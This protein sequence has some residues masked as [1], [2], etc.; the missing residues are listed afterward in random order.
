MGFF[1]PTPRASPPRCADLCARSGKAGA[2]SRGRNAPCAP[3]SALAQGWSCLKIHVFVKFSHLITS[4]QCLGARQQPSSPSNP[5]PVQPC[6]VR[7]PLCPSAGLLGPGAPSPC[8]HAASWPHTCRAGGARPGCVPPRTRGTTAPRCQKT[9]VPVDPQVPQLQPAALL[10]ENHRAK[11]PNPITFSKDL[12]LVGWRNALRHGAG[13]QG[14]G[15][16]APGAVR[17]AWDGQPHPLLSLPGLWGQ[18]LGWVV[19]SLLLQPAGIEPWGCRKG[20]RTFP[21]LPFSRF[22]F[23]SSSALPYAMPRAAA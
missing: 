22:A 7:A 3:T 5:S 13:M 14:Q 4:R 21:F 6:G 16:A 12:D 19:L 8:R 15:E 23:P 2:R 10:A 11:S 20:A 17:S 18:F 1:L 9:K